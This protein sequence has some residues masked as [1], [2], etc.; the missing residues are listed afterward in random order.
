MKIRYWK[1]L[2]AL[3]GFPVSVIAGLQWWVAA[4]ITPEAIVGRLEGQRNCRASVQSVSVRMF[5]FPARVEIQ[6]LRVVP[7]DESAKPA[8]PGETFIDVQQMLLEVNMWS[9]LAGELDVHRALIDG[10]AMQTAK[11]TEGGNSL[12]LL[13][14]APGTGSRPAPQPV[15]L[16]DTDEIPAPD[17]GGSAEG[18]RPFHI[19]GFP[20]T[21]KLREA[22]IRNA[23]WTI[24]NRRR[25]S[26]QQ[27]RDCS[28]V[29]TGLT[30]DPGNP[31]NGGS[32][33][34]SAGTRLIIDS[35]RL[36]LR[37]IDFI[38]ALDGKYQLIDPATGYFNNNF[39]FEITVKNGSHLNRIP[40][41]VKLNERLDKLKTGLGL[42][43]ELPPEATLT[44]D[45]VLRARLDDGVIR[46]TDDVFFPFDT[47]QL[48]L[49]QDSW[50]S[51]R[52]EEHVFTGRLLASGPVSTSAVTGLREFLQKRSGALTDLVSKTIL[53]KILNKDGQVE[54]PF[55]SRSE[56][57]RPKVSLAETFVAALRRAGAEAGKDLLKDAIEGGDDL[58]NIIDAVKG[59]R[60]SGN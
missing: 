4:K 52:D 44:A 33:N 36:N 45:T 5:S 26:V 47:Y 2:A 9:L 32:A 27:F 8:T 18:E 58:E 57:G 48:A 43:F 50:L 28:F 14:A 42:A 12:R 39:L 35:K 30:L 56:I 51:L 54:L 3:I 37:T 6:G 46:L 19:S 21:S 40:T 1:S 16:E 24:L 15:T 10:V 31:A 20:V 7:Q 41:L 55:E 53:E 25:D 13:L 59:L 22:R 29:L 11:W 17:P 60:K 23:T 38:V 34:V 49:D